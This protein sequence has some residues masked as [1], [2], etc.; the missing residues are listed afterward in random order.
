[1]FKCSYFV[2]CLVKVI[3]KLTILKWIYDLQLLRSVLKKLP[4]SLSNNISEELSSH[5]ML[6]AAPCIGVHCAIIKCGSSV[7]VRSLSVLSPAFLKPEPKAKSEEQVRAF[8]IVSNM[9]RGQRHLT[10]IHAT[11]AEHSSCTRTSTSIYADHQI[12]YTAKMLCA[13]H[14][15]RNHHMPYII[16]H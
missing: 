1:M 5:V 7:P 10:S 13:R 11:R 16:T 12:R 2:E 9:P 8:C 14:I 6:S 4:G 15:L 3:L